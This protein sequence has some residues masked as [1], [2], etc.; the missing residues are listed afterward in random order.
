MYISRLFKLLWKKYFKYMKAFGAP[1]SCLSIRCCCQSGFFSRLD[2][3]GYKK[4]EVHT[5]PFLPGSWSWKLPW[6]GGG[7]LPL[8]PLPFPV[9]LLEAPE[10]GQGMAGLRNRIRTPCS[11][12]VLISLPLCC[13]CTRPSHVAFFPWGALSWGSLCRW[14]TCW[15]PPAAKTLLL[16]YQ[17]A[18]LGEPL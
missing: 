5:C 16:R 11:L 17:A 8:H 18:V 14:H 6:A 10:S 13:C 4:A 2:S 7:L 3:T 1:K 15:L 9:M 12:V